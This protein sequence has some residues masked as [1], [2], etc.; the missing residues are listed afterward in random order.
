MKR[1]RKK[2]GHLA[3]CFVPCHRFEETWVTGTN[4]RPLVAPCR[5]DWEAG[6]KPAP[7]LRQ[8]LCGRSNFETA[9]RQWGTMPTHIGM[10]WAARMSQG[11]PVSPLQAQSWVAR[12]C[13]STSSWGKDKLLGEAQVRPF[14]L[15]Q[16]EDQPWDCQPHLTRVLMLRDSTPFPPWTVL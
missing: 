6:K 3:V 5:P 15:L 4:P 7:P 14:L 2:E 1:K 8:R 11:L 9:H 13:L 16:D 12:I 10:D